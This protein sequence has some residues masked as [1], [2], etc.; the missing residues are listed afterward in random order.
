[1]PAFRIAGGLLL[2]SISFE[3]MA[4]LI[5][6]LAVVIVVSWLRLSIAD[7]INRLLGIVLAALAVQFVI[8][9]I[10]AAVRA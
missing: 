6:G 8:D 1:M 3:M 10:R 4:G 5:G 2:F 7:R 9:G